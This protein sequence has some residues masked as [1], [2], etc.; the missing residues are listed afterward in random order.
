MSKIFSVVELET[1]TG[2]S[3]SGYMG[4]IPDRE[5][6]KKSDLYQELLE[7]CGDTAS[8]QVTVNSYTYGDGEREHA[9]DEDLEYIRSQKDFTDRDEVEWLQ[10]NSFTI[11]PKQEQGMSY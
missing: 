5:D 11:Y 6:V 2:I 1:S 7:D 8:I 3:D 9:D 10:S 4:G